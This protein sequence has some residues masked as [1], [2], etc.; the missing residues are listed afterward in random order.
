MV[1]VTCASASRG[2]RKR[3]LK[4][5]K[6]FWGDRKSHIRNSKN[7]VMKALAY[8]TE[9]RKHKKR[10][11]RSL[12]ITRVNVAAR[13]NGISY[14]KLIH[15]LKKANVNI[16]RKMLAELAIHDPVSFSSIAEIAKNAHRS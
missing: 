8:H 13:I 2:R 14:G 9:H 15:G 11:F 5:A 7:A 4:R 6:G 16:N 10:D 12:W 3:W 1:R